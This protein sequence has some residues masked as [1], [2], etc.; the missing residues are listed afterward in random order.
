MID[1]G[2]SSVTRRI[3]IFYLLF[4]ALGQGNSLIWCGSMSSPSWS[5]GCRTLIS[6]LGPALIGRSS[7]LSCLSAATS[8]VLGLRSSCYGTRVGFCFERSEFSE[9]KNKVVETAKLPFNP[10]ITEGPCPKL[11][12]CTR[13][14]WDTVKFGILRTGGNK[15]NFA[16]VTLL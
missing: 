3:F 9:R 4:S 10:P 14:I 6:C 16:T 12:R 11:S 1:T 15:C 7:R 8:D 2:W 13:T 5:I